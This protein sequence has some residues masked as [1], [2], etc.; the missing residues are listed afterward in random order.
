M[1]VCNGVFKSPLPIASSTMVE[2]DPFVVDMTGVTQ[3]AG[4]LDL[5]NIPNGGVQVV[6]HPISIDISE[7]V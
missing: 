2:L 7:A 3:T 1:G 5:G 6:G 4:K